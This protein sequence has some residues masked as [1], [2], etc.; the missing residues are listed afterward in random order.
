ME[1]RSFHVPIHLAVELAL[2]QRN[3]HVHTVNVLC[4]PT[5]N[6]QTCKKKKNE[7]TA[8]HTE[9][10]RAEGGFGSSKDRVGE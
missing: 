2:N 6:V 1:V 8:A 9:H 10:N 5:H 3:T 7:R 4:P